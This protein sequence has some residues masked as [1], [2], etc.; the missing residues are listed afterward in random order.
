MRLLNMSLFLTFD[1]RIR[2]K[3]LNG[4][5]FLTFIIIE[6]K[7]KQDYYHSYLSFR[8]INKINLKELFEKL[9]SNYESLRDF[10]IS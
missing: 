5:M 7:K 3:K 8:Y 1:N 2:T 4:I 10:D 6:F 9:A